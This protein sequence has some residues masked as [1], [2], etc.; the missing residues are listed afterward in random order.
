MPNPT[1]VE[2]PSIAYDVSLPTCAHVNWNTVCENDL[3][4]VTLLLKSKIRL[5]FRWVWKLKL[6]VDLK[7]TF[8]AVK[9]NI[10]LI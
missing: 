3:C 2:L 1:V 9:N 8:C 7:D 4:Y 6:K 5:L 10:L